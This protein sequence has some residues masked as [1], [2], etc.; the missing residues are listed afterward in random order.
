MSTLTAE[1]DHY[2]EYILTTGKTCA[3]AERLMG[4]Y[5]FASRFAHLERIVEIGPGRG[6]F[7]EQAR[8]RITGI[9]NSPGLV[10]H[11]QADGLDVRLGDAYSIP[12]ADESFDGAFSCWLFEH[13]ADP[14]RA[15]LEI[16][17]V[18]R[19]G[20]YACI[21][22]PSHTTLLTGFYDDYTH[23]RPFTPRACE[24]LGHSTGFGRVKVEYL[25][26]VG[27]WAQYVRLS[28]WLGAGFYM[29]CAGLFDRY[30]RKLGIA[31]RANVV[32]EVWK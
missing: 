13:L 15:M 9:D 19:P 31:N 20:G 29:A 16:R 11:H 26:K 28:R 21:I 5:L 17:R 10:A 22:V 30:G 14:A 1:R 8:N 4:S 2:A 6:W 18:L 25:Y 12:A 3:D 27:G 7:L 32:L 24:H 23:I